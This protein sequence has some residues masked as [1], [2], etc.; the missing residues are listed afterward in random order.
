MQEL[1]APVQLAELRTLER[2]MWLAPGRLESLGRHMRAVHVSKDEVLYRPGQPARYIYCVLQGSV[3]LS[4]SASRGRLLQLAVLA[5]GEFFGETALVRGWRRVSQA[6]ALQDSRVARIEAQALVT[7]VCGLPWEM[8]T[9]LTETVLKPLLVVS[10]RR[11]LFLVEH[12]PDRVALALWEY[13]GHPEAQRLRGL[14]PS[15]LTHEQ[16]AAV[17]GA[18]RPRVSLAL[19]RLEREGLFGREGKQIRVHERALR[20]YLERKYEFLL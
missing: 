5:R 1:K 6:A 2:L 8:F 7:H 14:L 18:A 3:G 20:R 10:L 13:A 12:L 19:K 9:G 11:S 15:T 16:I 17:V 4:L